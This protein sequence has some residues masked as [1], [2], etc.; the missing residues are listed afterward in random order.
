MPRR[1]GARPDEGVSGGRLAEYPRDGKREAVGKAKNKKKRRTRK[2]TREPL[3]SLGQELL[4]GGLGVLVAVLMISAFLISIREH[5]RHGVVDAVD[6]PQQT[7]TLHFEATGE[8]A[9][10]TW[11]DDT[12]FTL[13]GMPV[14]PDM[15]VKGTKVGIA[16]RG[17]K[18]PFTALR[19][20]V[21]ARP[22]DSGAA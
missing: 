4:L 6:A 1:A 20:Q 9:D 21:I 19:V 14:S 5:H 12:E 11:S 17:R 13:R 18:S 16:F 10:Y 8:R 3:L 22:A 15:L 2:E 7:F